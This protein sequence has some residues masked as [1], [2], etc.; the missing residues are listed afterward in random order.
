[1]DVA[2]ALTGQYRAG[3]T[4]LRDCIVKCPDDLWPAGTHPRAFWRIAY[5]VL[6][7]THFYAMPDH[8]TFTPWPGHV[9]HAIV[10]WEDDRLDGIPPVET[11]YSQADV[12]K[13]L[14]W[15]MESIGGWVDALDLDATESGFPWYPIPKLDHQIVNVR[16]LG[17][18]TG[19]LQELLM[20]RGIDTDWAGKR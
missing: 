5:H 15:V 4:M 17:T 14:D 8:E 1:M 2:G 12:L 11:T 16:H 3:L 19:Q 10:L 6:F 20:A 18:H 13:Y 9:N 7:Y